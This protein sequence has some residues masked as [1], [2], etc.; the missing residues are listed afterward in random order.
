MKSEKI[1]V[2]G[3]SLKMG[4]SERAS[5]N[6]ANMLHK[7]GFQVTFLSIF[8]QE[9]FFSLHDGIDLIEPEGFNRT[10]LSF[11]STL[12]WMRKR[13]TEVK[14][15]YVIAIGKFYSAITLLALGKSNIKNIYISERSSPHFKWGKGIDQFSNLIFKLFPPRGV[16]AQTT[17]AYEH[18]KKW[19]RSSTPFLVLP[20]PVQVLDD[21]KKK[22]KKLWIL[23]SGRLPDP[24]KGFDQLLR[25]YS[26]IQ[27]KDK[28]RLV[29]AG[30]GLEESGLKELAE[31]LG[32]A[33]HV[34]FPGPISNMESILSEASIFVMPS[35]SEG[36][37][38]A[39]VEAMAFGLTCVSFDFK[40][41]PRDII[42]D[43]IDGLIVKNGD[44]A[45]MAEKIDY[46]I[47]NESIRRQLGNE[48][49]KIKDRLSFENISKK[50]AK[51]LHETAR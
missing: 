31:E 29:I 37:P 32:V 26:L 30:G 9:N 4:G 2:I 13:A 27:N 21:P 12:L 41:G 48:A 17:Y 18:Q 16:L 47:E 23:A 33:Q 3:P 14:P 38:N 19:H 49:S 51:F 6:L 35:R 40:A 28:W 20:N 44:I 15:K 10:K 34:S 5:C 43:G 24:L 1:I 22:K 45:E 7:A 42:Q 25:A 46:L 36:F 50:L 39:L 11:F 8:K